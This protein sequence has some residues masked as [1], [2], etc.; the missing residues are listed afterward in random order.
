MACGLCIVSTDAGGVPDLVQN[1]REALLVPRADPEAMAG[2]VTRILRDSDLASRLSANARQKAE[3]HA[4]E[5]VL[6]QWE[7]LLVEVARGT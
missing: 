5:R 6:N 7:D 4:W 1:E 2:A 3:S